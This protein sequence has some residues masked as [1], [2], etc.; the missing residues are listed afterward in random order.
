MNIAEFKKK[1]V[2]TEFNTNNGWGFGGESGKKYDYNMLTLKEGKWSY[3]HAKCEIFILFYDRNGLSITEQE[4]EELI[5][6]LE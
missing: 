2:V 1:A 5:S 3:R 4:F 6:N